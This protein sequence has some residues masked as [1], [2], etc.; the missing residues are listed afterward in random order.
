MQHLAKIKYF[1][2]F[3][4]RAW[5]SARE[6]GR[7]ES[8]I[9]EVFYKNN[10]EDCIGWNGLS[11]LHAYSMYLDAKS[12]ST[13]LVILQMLCFGL[14]LLLLWVDFSGFLVFDQL[15]ALR[16]TA[17][18]IVSCASLFLTFLYCNNVVNRKAFQIVCAYHVMR[19]NELLGEQ[20][21][22]FSNNVDNFLPDMFELVRAKRPSK[23][24][25][26]DEI[27][28]FLGDFIAMRKGGG[29]SQPNHTF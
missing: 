18:L 27:E 11:F 19:I 7:F 10:R 4:E 9:E 22:P 1:F 3:N 14:I 6:L 25:T 2:H 5:Q 13:F 15:L 17:L 28:M 8:F 21:Y 26:Q 20:K 29:S 24:P 16:N 12:N 23:I